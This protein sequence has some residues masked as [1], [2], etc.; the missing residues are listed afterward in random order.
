MGHL[1]LSKLELALSRTEELTGFMASKLIWM[2]WVFMESPFPTSSTFL[3]VICL[4]MRL[5]SLSFFSERIARPAA[6]GWRVTTVPIAGHVI[7]DSRNDLQGNWLVTIS[8]S[9]YLLPRK[10]FFFRRRKKTRK[11]IS[12]KFGGF[13]IMMY[14]C[15]RNQA[16]RVAQ[17]RHTN[18]VSHRDNHGGKRM[19]KCLTT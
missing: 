19:C 18:R 1:T 6:A 2:G 17:L 12:N 7:T 11:I 16:L 13:K 9:C 4:A 8:L 3:K 5:S 10:I 14:F 15:T